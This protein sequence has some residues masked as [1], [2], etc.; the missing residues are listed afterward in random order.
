[1][2]WPRRLEPQ[3]TTA[4]NVDKEQVCQYPADTATWLDDAVEGALVWP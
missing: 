2:V 4:P 1:M 3:H